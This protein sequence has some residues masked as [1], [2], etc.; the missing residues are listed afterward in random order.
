MFASSSH[1]DQ[2]SQDV[3]TLATFSFQSGENSLYRSVESRNL[4]G[5][6]KQNTLQLQRQKE[7]CQDF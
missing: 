6:S 7:K 1:S 5:T 3:Q 2:N 4:A